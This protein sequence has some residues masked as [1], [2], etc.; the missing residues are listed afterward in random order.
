MLICLKNIIAIV[1][2]FVPCSCYYFF[3]LLLYRNL[4]RQRRLTELKNEFIGNITHELKTPISTVGVA[5]EAI[6]NFNA[7]HDTARTKEYLHIAGNE[8]QRLSLL[9]DKVL[10]LL[11]LKRNKLN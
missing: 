3:F 6:Q 8:L 11:C 5:I 10:R 1:I 4:N 2:F 7:L 9:V